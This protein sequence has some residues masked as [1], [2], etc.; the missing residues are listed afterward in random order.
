LI[1]GFG[2]AF[3]LIGAAAI[4][5][6]IVCADGEAQ[7]AGHNHLW[8]AISAQRS[9]LLGPTLFYKPGLRPNTQRRD[10]SGRRHI[11]T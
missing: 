3:I 11:V 10:P 6:L 7:P 1:E 9:P 5:A 4:I 2:A 8:R